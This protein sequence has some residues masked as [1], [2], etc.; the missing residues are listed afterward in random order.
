MSHASLLPRILTLLSLLAS[1][2]LTGTACAQQ[3]ETIVCIRH[4]EKPAQEI[5][6]INAQGLNRALALPDVLLKKYPHPQFIFAPGTKDKVTNRD[7]KIEYSY[8]R[9][10]ITIEPTAIRAGLPVNADYGFKDIKGLE[11]ELLKPAYQNSMVYVAWEHRAL[12]KMVTKLVADLGGKDTVPEWPHSDY[13]SIFLITIR[14]VNK[15]RTVNFRVAHEGI[16]PSTKFP[17]PAR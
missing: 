3:T 10:L 7:T 4:G 14:T 17:S 1:A 16:Q 2:A 6:Q 15:T 11:R 8:V 12:Q 9:P 5:G 13:D